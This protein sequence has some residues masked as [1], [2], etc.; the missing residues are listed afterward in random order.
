MHC[1]GQPGTLPGKNLLIF[2]D[3][4]M[5]CYVVDAFAEKVF[6]GNPAGVCILENWLS[7]DL[8]QKLAVENNLSETA[9][10]VRIRNGYHLRWFTPG[11]E[12]DLCGHATLATAFIIM[13]FYETEIQFIH[14]ES[15]G[16]ELTVTRKGDLYEMDFPSIETRPYALTEAMI[17]ALGVTPVEVYKGRDLIFLLESED[18]VKRLTPDFEKIKQF[19]EGLAVFVTAKGEAFDFVTRAFWPK[20]NVNEDPVCGSM[21]CSL[22]PYWNK[23]LNKT[24]MISRQVSK[25]GGTIYLEYCGERVKMSGRAA[26]YS[27][28]D[29]NIE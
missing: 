17:E 7:D 19:P 4:K 18:V 8:M 2:E 23:K 24:E 15:K 25:R 3:I 29:I 11:G 9:F 22:L 13:R 12:I 26:L 28:A 16:G 20:L 5:K 21:Y 10:A 27:S 14:F 6:E 1:I